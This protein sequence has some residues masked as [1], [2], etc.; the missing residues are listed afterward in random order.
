M[1][2]KICFNC[3]Q[4]K[5]ESEF[6]KNISKKDG[7]A[8]SCKLCICSKKYYLKYNKTEHYKKYNKKYQQTEKSKQYRREYAK[9]Y[10]KRESVK[11]R[12]RNYRKL[13]KKEN[14]KFKLACNLRNRLNLAIQENWEKGHTIKL[15]SCS[16]EFLKK[17]LESQ[18]VE[19]MTWAN[20]GRGGWHIDHIR[21]CASFDLSK[22]EEQHKCFHYTNLQPLWAKENLSKSAKY[23]M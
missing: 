6:A 23:K 19:G 15:L 22:P 13:Y 5:I 20:Y 8:S 16:I 17:H 21:P 12:I 4:E 10:T 1:K 11:E 3:K 18:F 7:L 9:E 14:I 2:T